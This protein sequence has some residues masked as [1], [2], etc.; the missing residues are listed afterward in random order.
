MHARRANTGNSS[1]T[2]MHPANLSTRTRGGRRRAL[3]QLD[4]WAL[5]IPG[6]D[7]QR[8][9]RGTDQF[10]CLSTKRHETDLGMG[11]AEWE[12]S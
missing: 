3:D 11:D 10:K 7:P 2:Y 12:T 6:Q 1:T 8:A 9:S 5:S 4:H